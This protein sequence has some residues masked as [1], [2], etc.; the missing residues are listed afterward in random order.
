MQKW[1]Y[2]LV[3]VALFPATQA[4]AQVGTTTYGT[5]AGESVTTGDYNS[6]F[7]ERAGQKVNSSHNGT[8]IGY[9]AGRWVTNDSDNTC[10]GYG[11]GAGGAFL[12]TDPDPLLG[13]V[14]P[15]PNGLDNVF[16]GARAGMMC[17]ST[18]NTF[19]G[20]EAGYSNT[21]GFDNTFIGEQAG[22]LNTTGDDNTFVGE[23]A[24]YNNTTGDDNTAI[25]STAM[26]TITTGFGNT[27]VGKDAMYDVNTGKNNTSIG[28]WSGEDIGPGM[29]NTTVGSLAGTNIEHADM[30]TFIGFQA[31]WDN[32][33]TNDTS[34]ANSNTYVGSFAGLTNREGS[35]NVIMGAYADFSNINEN[36]GLN[37]CETS[38]F[39]NGTTPDRSND[40]TNVSNVSALGASIRIT[41]DN[42]VSLG[43]STIATGTRGITLGATAQT[44]HTDAVTIG[45]GAVSHANATVVIGNDTTVSWDPNIDGVTTLGSAAYRF[46]QAY[47]QAYTALAPVGASADITLTAD[48]GAEVDDSWQISAANSGDMTISTFA[49][50]AYVPVLTVANTGDV[51][52]AGDITLNSDARL[53]RDIAPIQDALDLVC[54][55][56]GVTYEWRPELHRGDDVHYGVIAQDVAGVLPD[57]VRESKDGVL[58]VNYVGF[59]PV[60][61]NAVGELREGLDNQRAQINLQKA[62]IKLL[63][64]QIALQRALLER[65]SRAK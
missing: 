51:T 22:Y 39:W 46:S 17:L 43:Y 58:S 32:N 44:T 35:Y 33:R 28:A 57:L 52:V 29:C 18:D 55:I 31:G 15:A 47:S 34:N 16:V 10:V 36:T 60:L 42:A 4:F 41:G 26:R 2:V 62:E 20:S 3:L 38:T 64:E 53:K 7:G 6:F 14:E 49:S 24:G 48:D 61:I 23:D 40:D 9:A 63:R 45:Y 30:N 5:N 11:A 13:E 50:G 21:T 12:E 1:F 65:L 25:G 8:F 37:A 54:D 59:I 27:A 56:K 19:V